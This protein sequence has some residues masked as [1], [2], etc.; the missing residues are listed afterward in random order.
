MEDLFKYCTGFDWDE[1][2]VNKNRERHR[3]SFVEC[4]Q[5]FFNEPVIVGDDEK[6]SLVERRW[7][8]LGRTDANR[9]L[10]VVFT[11]RNNLIRIISARDMSKKGRR[12]YREKI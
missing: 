8:L 10:F 3:V 7:F 4:E 6:H 2:N 9:F 12:I 11:L 5:D 1:G